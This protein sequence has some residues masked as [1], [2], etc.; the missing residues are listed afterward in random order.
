VAKVNINGANHQV[1]IEHDSA[2]LSYIVEKAQKL[3]DETKPTDGKPG[4][5]YGY[6]IQKANEQAGPASFR[7]KEQPVVDR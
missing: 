5:A 1:E 3:W 2:D 6:A 7:H 4:L